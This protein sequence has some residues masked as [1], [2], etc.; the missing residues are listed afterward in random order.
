MKEQILPPA[1]EG[2]PFDVEGSGLTRHQYDIC[3]ILID[4]PVSFR[5]VLNCM[6]SYYYTREQGNVAMN[7]NPVR[8]VFYRSVWESIRV[9]VGF[10]D[11]MKELEN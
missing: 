3:K 5:N 10:F 2:N 1:P 9:V 8:R 11:Q 7:G 4:D 6:G